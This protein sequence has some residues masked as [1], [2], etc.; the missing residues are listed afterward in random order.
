MERA[1]GGRKGEGSGVEESRGHVNRYM[2]EIQ[3]VFLHT[4]MQREM[5]EVMA[6]GTWSVT[7]PEC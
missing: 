7:S 3:G 2:L 1:R 6:R 4:V 5:G